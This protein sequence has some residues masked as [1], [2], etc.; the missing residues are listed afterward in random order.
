MQLGNTAYVVASRELSIV[1]SVIIGRLWLGERPSRWRV[2][3]AITI[4][5]GVAALALTRQ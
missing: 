5:C 4:V 1:F 2:L 3:S